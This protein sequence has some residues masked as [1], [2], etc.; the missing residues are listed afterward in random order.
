ME[1]LLHQPGFLGTSANF[2][3]DMTLVVSLAVA[4]LFTLGFVLARR[5]Q[6]QWHRWVQTCAATLNAGLVL[7]MMILPFRDFVLPGIPH[8]LDE[9]FYALSTLHGVIGASGLLLGVFVTLRG[10]GL[11]P[12]ALRFSNYKLF[13]RASYALYL[14]ATAA[15]LLLYVTWF[16]DN[17]NPP[18]YGLPPRDLLE[19]AFY[20]L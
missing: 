18:S 7:W 9:S 5:Q 14:A 13:M 6:Y 4:A 10:N 2:A 3:A 16:V 8:R 20:Y 12:G 17:P 1:G 11:V 19:R 15:G